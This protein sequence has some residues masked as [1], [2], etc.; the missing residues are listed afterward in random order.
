MNNNN[1]DLIIK[2]V[3]IISIVIILVII[4]YFL[5]RD[6][7]VKYFN[8]NDQKVYRIRPDVI[9]S[10][11]KG[12]TKQEAADY[13]AGLS[14]KITTLVH[15]MKE[16]GLPNPEVADRLYRRWSHCVL[17]E[18]SSF[19]DAVATTL[20]KGVEIRICIRNDK[21][22]EDPNT[23]MFVILHELAHI[24]SVTIDHTDEFYYNFSYVTKLASSLGLYKP[25]DFV[26]SPKTYCGIVINTTPCSQGSC[27]VNS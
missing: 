16:H 2:A 6:D 17:R 14:A 20:G 24:M 18:T 12:D 23:S 11:I 15:Y 21:G 8:A 5:T 4:I 7:T 3:L 19:D 10:V 26:A 13:L 22:F 1:N 25:E 27:P 9:N